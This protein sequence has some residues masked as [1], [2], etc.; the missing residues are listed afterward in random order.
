MKVRII[1]AVIV[2]C[3]LSFV[4][5][6]GP[7]STQ[8][9]KSEQY[10][11]Y[12]LPIRP[13]Q[14]IEAP[15]HPFSSTDHGRPIRNTMPGTNMAG[16]SDVDLPRRYHSFG[17]ND[18]STPTF[19][20]GSGDRGLWLTGGEGV[21][22]GN[23]ASLELVIPD[24]AIGTTLYAPT[25]MSPGNACIETV[26][27]HWRYTGM[28]ATAHGHGFWDWCVTDGV[29]GWQVFEFMDSAW[30]DQ[31]V[32][33]FRGR[34]HYWTQ[35]YNDA[36]SSWKG[37]LYNFNQGQWE[38]K[39]SISG[40]NVSGFG[41]L[42][43]TMW[44]SHYLMDST[45]VCPR[46]PDIRASDLQLYINGSW[47]GVTDSTSLNTLGPYGRCWVESSYTFRLAR[48]LDTWLARTSTAR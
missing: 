43:W 34:A 46:F 22:A 28:S 26:T 21:Y 6:S 16:R 24:P 37:M 25:H 36:P 45:Q 5:F 2:A 9:L 31:Y 12:G 27:A 20:P 47:T 30:T 7:A 42:G 35:V 39:T 14:D 8:I 40:S 44:E 38:E 13:G 11:P 23:D 19:E 32:R 17:V 3:G 1:T 4:S 41:Q 15:P 18:G 10:L 29:G 33:R 48:D